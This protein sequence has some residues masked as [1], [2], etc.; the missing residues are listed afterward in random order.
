MSARQLDQAVAHLEPQSGKR[1]HTHDDAG[2]A[3]RDGH[4]D[5]V[6]RAVFQRFKNIQA[7]LFQRFGGRAALVLGLIGH[8]L[9]V[10]TASVLL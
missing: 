1:N 7:G 6:V 8:G 2:H 4:T 10:F 3:A 9:F 5:D